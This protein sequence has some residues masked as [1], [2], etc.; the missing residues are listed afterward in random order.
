MPATAVAALA[1]QRQHAP[2]METL[3]ASNITLHLAGRQ[4]EA[5]AARQVVDQLAPAHLHRALR[6]VVHDA[7][8][9][10]RVVSHGPARA[11]RREYFSCS[12]D[13]VGD[14]HA[15]TSAF[16]R[17]ARHDVLVH[18][19]RTWRRSRTPRTP[20]RAPAQSDTTSAKTQKPS[21]KRV[22]CVHSKPTTEAC[23]FEAAARD[24][25]L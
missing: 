24:A 21:R 3:V 23:L 2:L 4:V 5:A 12:Q 19:H 15:T 10:Q 13:R 25:P 6:A 16:R 9:E 1:G 7:E 17:R 20:A 11:A 14:D 8:P 22:L 18:V